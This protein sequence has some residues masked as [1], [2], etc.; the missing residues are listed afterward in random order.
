MKLRIYCIWILGLCLSPVFSQNVEK[1]QILIKN[2]DQLYA[3]RI[4]GED[5]QRLIGKVVFQHEG[6]TM[7]CDSAVFNTTKNMLEA[8]GRI[9][10]E[11]GDTL[12]LYGDVLKYN[13]DT[14]IADISGR[15]RL[16]DPNVNMTTTKLTYNR[17]SGIASYPDSAVTISNKDRLRSKKGYY[18]THTQEFA[19]KENVVIENPEYTIYTDTLIQNTKTDVS[20][21]KGPTE[22]TS[23]DSYIYCENGWYDKKND[24]C[25][26]NENAYVTAENNIMKGDSLYYER[27]NGYGK[28]IG[29]VSIEDTVEKIIVTGH[30]AESFRN[31]EKYIVTD[32]AQ[33]IQVFETDSLFM[34]ADTLYA[35]EDSLGKKIMRAY[36]GV[37][38]FKPDMQGVCDSLVYT[39]SDSLLQMFHAPILWNEK[40]QITGE[41]ISLVMSKGKLYLMYITD[42]ALIISEEDSIK[43][44]QVAGDRMIG[45]FLDNELS[46]VNVYENG[47]SIYFPKE[48]GSDEVIGLNEVVCKDMIIHLE[49]KEVSRIVFLEKPVGT[50]HPLQ[51]VDPANFRL[52]GFQ[53]RAEI[54]PIDRFDIFRDVK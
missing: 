28:A 41:H 7:Y 30:F 23:K 18:N 47:K 12:D 4:N 31:I 11:Q 19:F 1:R 22:I 20:Y 25:Q 26:F 17:T 45:H 35:T 54:R 37:R 51:E 50:L 16:I 52:D 27:G 32:S 10:L 13:G 21:F 44:N 49:D 34:H 24:I 3:Q 39:Q 2:A 43:Y 53:W 8:F 48:D 38:M 9:H 42:T 6:S 33:M 36:F 15:V 40:N 46:R 5:I 14:K 29:N